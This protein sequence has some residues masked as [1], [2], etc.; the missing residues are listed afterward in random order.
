MKENLIRI[1]HPDFG[2]LITVDGSVYSAEEIVIHTPSEHTID[3]KKY[4]ME[5]SILHF[6]ITQG[7]IAKHATLNFLFE[8]APGVENPFLE[9]LDYFN[10]PGALRKSVDIK[11]MVY[12]NKINVAPEDVGDITSLT[13]FSFFTYQGSLSMPPCT[14]NTIV[15]VASKPLKIGTTA[16][17]LFQEASR[18]PDMMDNRGNVIVSNW[19]SESARKIQELNGRPVFHH[20][21]T[22]CGRPTVEKPNPGHYEKIR[23]AFTSYFY[24]SNDSP[25]GLPNSYVVSEGEAKGE[26]NRPKPKGAIY[27]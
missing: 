23:K 2:R 1:L 15:Y 13:P 26:G 25:S 5:I 12:I 9:D 27:A 4:D 11:E 24:V 8:K 6:G 20:K 14:E 7:D 16:L 17:Q 21:P 3:G 19:V 18:I 10:L 22:N